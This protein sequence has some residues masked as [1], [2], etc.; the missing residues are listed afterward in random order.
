MQLD[1]SFRFDSRGRTAST[2]EGEH[3]PGQ[4]L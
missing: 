4:L 1:Y 2:D 3:V